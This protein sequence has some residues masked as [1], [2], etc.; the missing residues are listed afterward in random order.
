M[1]ILLTG[2]TGNLGIELQK[3]LKN[4]I[5]PTREEFD[6]TNKDQVNEFIQKNKIEMIIHTAALTNVRICEENKSLAW[7]TN[8]E[9]TKNLIEAV[10]KF[11]KN[12]KFVYVSTACVFEGKTGMYKEKDI[13]YPENFYAL[14]KL[15]GEREVSKLQNFLILRTNFVAKAK[16][17]YPK[18]FIDRFG[19]YL[20]AE[21]VAKGIYEILGS[22]LNGIVHLV[23]D[24]KLSMFDLAKITTS[25]VEPMTIDDYD[26]PPLTMDMSLDSEIWKKYELK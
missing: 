17:P 8:V 23:G 16:W 22:E 20:F 10:I 18:A 5:S 13:P 7:E 9:G 24:R 26:G 6:I 2:G 4:C 15:I 25:E 1:S 19:T 11:Q 12:L 21:Q 14:T 3:I